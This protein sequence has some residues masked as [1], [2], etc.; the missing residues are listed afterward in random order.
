M[1]SLK[2]TLTLWLGILFFCVLAA[3]TV[4]VGVQQYKKTSFEVAQSLKQ[5][6]RLISRLVLERKANIFHY[7]SR[8]T[9]QI[10]Q[11]PMEARK[12]VNKLMMSYLPVEATFYLLN[13]EGK[14]VSVFKK[15][16]V[17]FV[18]MNLSNLQDVKK[19][20]KT[21]HS[22]VSKIYI[23]P[24]TGQRVLSM[25]FPS[26]QGWILRVDVSTNLFF[27]LVRNSHQMVGAELFVFNRRG[28]VYDHPAQQ[29][30]GDLPGL[31]LITD[32]WGEIKKATGDFFHFHLKNRE[33]VGVF[34]PLK[35]FDLIVCTAL[36]ASYITR[37]AFHSMA[38][39]GGM[40]LIALWALTAIN[41]WM[42]LIFVIRPLESITSQLAH[43]TIEEESV[44]PEVLGKGSRELTFL[45]DRFNQM[46]ERIHHQVREIARLESM[47]RNIL[48]SSPAIVL[49][50]DVK[51]RVWYM[52]HAG[53]TFFEISRKEAVGKTL[54]DLN[55]KLESYENQIQE[56]LATS[57]PQFIRAQSWL[58]GSMVDG[59]IYPLVANGT[60]GVVVQWI[61]VSEQY[62]A[63]EAYRRRLEEIFSKMDDLI[64]VVGED[65]RVEMMNRK[66]EKRLGKKGVG[67]YCY[68]VIRNRT[69][70]CPKCPYPEIKKGKVV[71]ERIQSSVDG[72]YYD[73]LNIPLTNEDGT[74]SKL[75]I[76]RDV[77]EY[78]AVQKAL[79]ASES[80]F[81]ALF[82]GAPIG[83][84]VHQDGKFVMVNK[85]LAKIV[86]YTPR[87][88]VGMSIFTIIHPDDHEFVRERLKSIHQ[89]N[90]T[91]EVA[92]EKYVRKNGSTA[93]VLVTGI[94]I[95]YQGKLSVQ[96]VVVDLTE[97]MRLQTSLLRSE[98][99]SAQ[100]L[101]RALDPIII[102]DSRSLEIVDFNEPATRFFGLPASKIIGRNYLEFVAPEEIDS[103]KNNAR[104]LEER[105]TVSVMERKLH[106][107]TGEKIVNLS[108]VR[109]KTPEGKDRNVTFIK[110]LTEFI[111]L[112]Q[113]LAQAQKQ[114]SLWQMAG[115][116][117]HDFNNLL[118]IMFGYL[119]M[120]E[121]TSDKAK[122]EEYF[123][124]LRDIAIRAKDLVQNILLFSRESR[125]NQRVCRIGEIVSSA[126]NLVRPTLGP[127]IVLEVDIS[128][129]EDAVF[130]DATQ[131]VQVILNLLINAKDAIGDE[132]SGKITLKT[133]RKELNEASSKALK[134]RPGP[135]LEIL[136][137]DTGMG[138][139]EEIRDKIFDPFFTTK[140]KG[141]RKGTGLG[142]AIV[143][144]IIRNF[145]G[146][147]DFT[148]SQQGTTFQVLLPLEGKREKECSKE[149][150]P[151]FV[152]GKGSILIVEDE[153]M[154]RGLLKEM[155]SQ[156]G[157]Q[158]ES[159]GDGVEAIE[160]LKLDPIAWDIVLMDL[161]MPKMDGEEALK[162][163]K[164]RYP[165]IKVIIMSGMVDE[166][167]QKRLLEGGAAAFVK[168]PVSISVLSQILFQI[169]TE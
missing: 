39:I 126:L 34:L 133:G 112:Q 99:F 43:F 47:L 122:Q 156:L 21:G 70:I 83:M 100:I 104:I 8:V 130:V 63:R 114:E 3:L 150:K 142:L 155:L 92:R 75:V 169:A 26:P 52:N 53:E 45:I 65:Y 55:P 93:E 146:S 20:I 18:G 108:V 54:H 149:A 95:V 10:P 141:S 152:P 168:K 13:R 17:S 76:L 29:F 157:Y 117:A 4:S 2:V 121:L 89:E 60:E 41:Y 127:K 56:V 161:A 46:S 87:E 66:M 164:T 98:A 36:P 144:S 91:A 163:I 78:I 35:P 40:G 84:S 1:R 124:K 25:N 58:K 94:P 102:T 137:S 147:V 145:G 50:L 7:L 6:N 79:E 73:V 9:L 24:L 125:G 19:A 80:A 160:K 115:G 15:P 119:D 11:D 101:E 37:K 165:N 140:S 48:D 135:Y 23:S 51:G 129:P 74:V 138:I 59:A 57:E 31:G 167:T 106:L 151:A 132:I 105:G 16:L 82:E 123:R 111:Q 85:A 62:K 162:I 131:M 42:I 49:A 153:E 38:S 128:S 44:L 69:D 72:K 110:D 139:P 67:R 116:F 33:M 159:V 90:R 81:R 88:M 154:L 68:E 14:I 118:A 27:D 28:E 148:T 5:T 86:G 158:A 136:V 134:L 32:R 61:D 64:Y 113:Q 22:T 30:P 77:N 109:V 97:Q 71:K 166:E 12:F 120:I 107:P 143:H 103:A 96:T